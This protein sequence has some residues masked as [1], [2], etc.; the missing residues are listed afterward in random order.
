MKKKLIFFIIQ[1]AFTN[2][3]YAQPVFSVDAGITTEY[4]ANLLAM[5]YSVP[6]TKNVSWHTTLGVPS[7]SIGFTNNVKNN[8]F[9]LVVNDSYSQDWR[10][11]IA[12]SKEKSIAEK[13]TLVYGVRLILAEFSYGTRSYADE[14]GN[15]LPEVTGWET[16]H[17]MNTVG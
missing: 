8:R 2:V 7:Y 4:G 15:E 10:L 16:T 12:Y 14:N 3:S 6:I 5:N 1:L 9:T 17:F 13:L 11:R